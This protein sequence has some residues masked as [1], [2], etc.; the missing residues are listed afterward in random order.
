MA[1]LGKHRTRQS[2]NVLML[3]LFSKRKKLLLDEKWELS[4]KVTDVEEII[5]EPLN[6]FTDEDE[7]KIF[8]SVADLPIEERRLFIVYALLDCSLPK[9][10]KLFRVDVKTI[11]TRIDEISE[12]IKDKRYDQ[13]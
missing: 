5:S 3:L 8:R 10:A 13:L 9:V 6:I 2:N 11:K 4:K 1:I 12:K 7:W